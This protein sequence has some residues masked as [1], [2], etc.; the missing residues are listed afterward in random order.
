[1]V[2]ALGMEYPHDVADTLINRIRVHLMDERI[3]SL[4]EADAELKLMT[5]VELVE[6][7]SFVLEDLLAGRPTVGVGSER[8]ALPEA[9]KPGCGEDGPVHLHRGSERWSR[10]RPPLHA[11][12]REPAHAA[13]HAGCE[14]S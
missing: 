11:G 9:S 2:R 4:D 1:M 14:R 13:M 10:G 6:V 5:H 3:N 7:I 12:R 8:F